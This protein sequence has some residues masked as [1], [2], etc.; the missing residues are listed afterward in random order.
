MNSGR[1]IFSIIFMLAL[2]AAPAVIAAE[3]HN[4]EQV[5]FSGTGSGTFDSISTPFGF[6]IWCEDESNNRYAGRCSGSMYFYALGITRA[7][8]G[9]V[10]END[11]DEYVMS[12]FSSRDDSIDCVL[13]NS[14]PV[15]RGPRNRV[16]VTCTEP[17]GTGMSTTAVVNVTGP[18]ED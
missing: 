4:S 7:V 3:P 10:E 18:P 13:Q 9:T 2:A 11:A 14:N 17:I 6:W 16:T 12:V 5:I 8:K 1:R 15:V